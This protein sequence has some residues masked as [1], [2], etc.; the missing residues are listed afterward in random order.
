MAYQE[1]EKI[2]GLDAEYLAGHRFPYQEDISLVENVEPDDW[3]VAPGNTELHVQAFYQQDG[4]GISLL[5]AN[6]SDP[7]EAADFG[8]TFDRLARFAD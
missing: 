3:L 1:P 4:F 6:G 7:E 8:D 2:I 5:I